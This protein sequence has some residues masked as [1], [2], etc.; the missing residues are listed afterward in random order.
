MLVQTF[1]LGWNIPPK[2]WD[3]FYLINFALRTAVILHC[4]DSTGC[5][6]YSSDL[7]PRWRDSITRSYLSAARPWC[8]SS[9][10]PNQSVLAWDLETLQPFWVQWG[11][12]MFKTSV[13]DDLSFVALNSWHLLCSCYYIM[14]HRCSSVY[15]HC[16]KWLKPRY[17]NLYPVVNCWSW[18]ELKAIIWLCLHLYKWLVSVICTWWQQDYNL[19]NFPVGGI[20]TAMGWFPIQFGPNTHTPLRMNRSSFD[21]PLILSALPPSH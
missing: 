19:L 18:L 20:L 2:I 5:W 10:P 14:V 4:T 15:L 12:D 3:G 11:Y 16:N 17:A 6:K 8:K 1:D 13:W 9:G 21:V 7:G